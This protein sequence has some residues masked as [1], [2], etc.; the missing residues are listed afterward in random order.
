M[1]YTTP[2]SGE[3]HA[4]S[5][6][7]MLVI[8]QFLNDKYRIRR[9]ILNGKVEFATLPEAGPS[10]DGLSRGFSEADLVYRPLTPEAILPMGRTPDNAK[11]MA[12]PWLVART[13]WSLSMTS[14]TAMS[15]SPSFRPRAIMPLLRQWE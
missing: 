1:D 2:T 13:T 3:A 6:E 11:R 4:A 7:A 8:E 5:Q 9:N 10:A 14:R 12:I 15:S